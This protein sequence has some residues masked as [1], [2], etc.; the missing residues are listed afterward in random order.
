[1][2]FRPRRSNPSHPVSVGRARRHMRWLGAWLVGLLCMAVMPVQAQ[3][4][5]IFEP[6]GYYE[7]V[8]AAGVVVAR[9]GA[10]S[11]VGFGRYDDRTQY[12]QLHADA[13]T[14][15]PS[16][17]SARGLLKVDFCVPRP[18]QSTCDTTA[19][20]DAEWITITA[21]FK[22]GVVGELQSSLGTSSS[23][24]TSAWL[25]DL[26]RN[27]QVAYIPAMPAK[28][29]SNATWFSF[30][31]LPI[32]M[33]HLEGSVMGEEVSFTTQVQLGRRYRFQLA[34][35][36]NAQSTAG[37]TLKAVSNFG[38][39]ALVHPPNTGEIGGIF[40]HN[41]KLQF[42]SASAP[43]EDQVAELQSAVALLNEQIAA[44]GEQ[45]GDAQAAADQQIQSLA[46]T[47]ATLSRQTA[48]A[49]AL[50][51]RE[52][53]APPPEGAVFLG[54]YRMVAD[55]GARPRPRLTVDLYLMPVPVPSAAR[56]APA[57]RR[58]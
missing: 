22:Y 3:P 48:Q 39:M 15:L 29:I 30:A 10:V 45:L 55:A 6:G 42:G 26:Q 53:G 25:V 31:D 17:A 50:L 2:S 18:G 1:M 37:G 57:L 19:P 7:N 9:T 4:Y 27:D 36:A 44:L 51:M 40:L 8:A 47:V 35:S 11:A 32:P 12:M 16:E 54:S 13:S 52:Q 46:A 33:P 58:R 56:P 38:H 34:G 21:R 23:I 5:R 43:L 20:A 28:S 14:V 24:G 49:G 41:L